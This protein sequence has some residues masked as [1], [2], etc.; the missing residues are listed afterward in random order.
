MYVIIAIIAA[1]FALFYCSYQIRLGAYVRSLCR[2][3]AAGHVVA[4]TFDDGPDPEQ[5][6]RVLDTLRE[7]GVRATFFLIGSKAEL[8]PEIVRRMAAEGHA[9]GIH[10]WRPQPRLPDA[11]KRGDGGRTSCGAG[12]RCGEITGGGNRPFPAPLRGHEPDG[13]TRRETDAKPLRGLEHPLARHA[14]A[15]QPRGRGTPYPP[16]AGRRQGGSCCT[17]TAPAPNACWHWCSTTSN[18][19][20]TAR[21]PYANCLKPRNHEDSVTSFH[22]RPA[23]CRG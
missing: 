2:N 17:T 4:L 5:T 13:G 7:H 16:T 23:S 10:T 8:H 22:P 20:G 12:S 14:P 6:P 3:R 21:R 18:V 11:A 1:G 15:P 19:G 9:I